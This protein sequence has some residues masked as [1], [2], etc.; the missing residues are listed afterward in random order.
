VAT[1]YP[2]YEQ[3]FYHVILNDTLARKYFVQNVFPLTPTLM[4]TLMLSYLPNDIIFRA[5][6]QL[7]R[8]V[9]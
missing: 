1:T 8:N 6:V 4:L 9:R 3:K 5:S 2:P 7:T